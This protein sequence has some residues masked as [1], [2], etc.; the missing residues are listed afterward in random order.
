MAAFVTAAAQALGGIDVLVNNVGVFR[1]APLET[2]TE[3]VLDEA[4]DVNVKAAVMASQAAAPHMRRRG[5]G[6]IVNVASLGGLQAV[7]LL[8]PVLR[9]EGGA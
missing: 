2:L 8:S 4:F 7:A 1:K 5:G 6:A 9:V 3:D